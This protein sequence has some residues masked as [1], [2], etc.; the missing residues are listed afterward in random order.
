MCMFSDLRLLAV[1]PHIGHTHLVVCHHAS[2]QKPRSG[3]GLGTHMAHMAGVTRWHLVACHHVSVQPPP[4]VV[5]V[6][7]KCT[8]MADVTRWRR[9]P[10]LVGK[11]CALLR[12][13]R[14]AP[15]FARHPDAKS[16]CFIA[17]GKRTQY[18]QFKIVENVETIADIWKN[19]GQLGKIADNWRKAYICKNG[20]DQ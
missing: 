6:A 2:V 7:T 8:H 5:G 11:L 12:P 18:V 14:A 3:G 9:A 13:W 19:C 1:S 20:E 10:S 16:R 15:A 4:A 17:D